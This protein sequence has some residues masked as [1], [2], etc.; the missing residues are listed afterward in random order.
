MIRNL[1][2][3]L[4]TAGVLVLLYIGYTRILSAPQPD[5]GARSDEVIDLGASAPRNPPPPLRI[6]APQ[7]DV[8][9]ASGQ[10]FA[11]SR[12]DPR[13]GREIGRIR[14][15]SWRPIDERS[16]QIEI[17][18]PELH[19]RL[20]GGVIVVV[21][22]QRAVLSVDTIDPARMTPRRGRFIGPARIVVDTC[23]DDERT[24]L[25]ERPDDR[26]TIRLPD[27]EFDL[28]RGTLQTEA[29]IEV[30]S[31]QATLAGRG[32]SLVWNQAENRIESLRIEAGEQLSFRLRSGL[33]E[34]GQEPA[35]ESQDAPRPV[36]SAD[37]ADAS[38]AAATAGSPRRIVTYQCVL[39]GGVDADQMRGPER[40]GGLV[41]DTLRLL[42]DTG[43]QPNPFAGAPRNQADGTSR[44]ASAPATQ[45]R[46]S[47]ADRNERLVVRWNGPLT[48]HPLPPPA[49]PSP[50]RRQFEA[51]GEKLR[52]ELGDRLITGG[53]LVYHDES[54]R[55]WL[56][57]DAGPIQLTVGQRLSVQA[58]S[59]YIDNA[60]ENI[61]L[62]GDVELA[63]REAGPTRGERM[64]IRCG[65]WAELHLDRRPESAAP[66][67]APSAA[68]SAPDGDASMLLG[69]SRLR[70]AV[71]VGSASIELDQQWL[72]AERIE[73]EFRPAE[74]ADEP[75]GQLLSRVVATG[76][77]RLA[78]VVGGRR[79]AGLVQRVWTRALIGP[80]SPLR[81]E[82][83]CDQLDLAFAPGET[84]RARPTH[85]EASG[86][87]RLLDP[88]NH[89][90]AKGRRLVA[91]LDPRGR[92]TRGTLLGTA[93]RAA[94]LYVRPFAVRGE[95]IEF[96]DDAETV[97]LPGPARLAFS[98]QRGLRG[99][100][101]SN[102][103]P[104]HVSCSERLQLDG[105]A[106]TVRF[107]GNVA[108]RSGEESLSADALTLFLSD[109]PPPVRR[110]TLTDSL[111]LAWRSFRARSAAAS[112]AGVGATT[113]VASSDDRLRRRWRKEPLRIV[114]NQAVAR[115]E[116]RLDAAGRPRQRE[117]ISAPE[118]TL[119][120][121]TRT[122]Q[123]AGL[124]TLL[125]ENYALPGVS[126]SRAADVLGLPSSLISDGPSQTAMSASQSMK[127]IVGDD[128][129][130]RRD[131][132]VMEGVVR[133]RHVAG[134]EIV[135]LEA[136]LPEAAG[137]PELLANLRDRNAW[138]ECDRLEGYFDVAPDEASKSGRSPIRLSW[139][140]ARGRV[141]LRDQERAVTRSV[142]AQELEFDRA[143]A[144]VKVRGG[145]NP[146][147]P[148]R[149]IEENAQSGHVSTPAL[150]RYI[151][152][153]L[154]NRTV[155]ADRTSGT[156]SG[157]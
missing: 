121:P 89:V 105:A 53:K 139:I 23:T 80:E 111:G 59:A 52:V 78:E 154:K 73:A 68:T 77:V 20:P 115:S 118:L 67:S 141:Y 47:P 149:V 61:K 131:W 90:G 8:S 128:G 18:Q 155:R 45:P 82:L 16:N 110:P 106:N 91:E 50:P 71:F 60:G 27:L 55:L 156:I 76:D 100:Q 127:Y 7:G 143:N 113:A 34:P 15:E 122:V 58:D 32:L 36:D 140:T 48:L 134:R 28:E 13:S 11:Y 109:V 135:D 62:V 25:D 65:L 75:L 157:R 148:A 14:G 70:S 97:T 69:S 94:L 126:D 86:L 138:L 33:L 6:Q 107:L 99:E 22:G 119:E 66:G 83:S 117:T 150:S 12:Y 43:R 51:T 116:T 95:R 98:S 29:R 40:I 146:P 4:S 145:D 44:P 129:P 26:I 1:V 133:C 56:Q 120:I 112:A 125:V 54:K 46:S 104:I 108:A 144:L 9:I 38:A 102:P 130:Q 101:R 37:G 74:R 63:L 147:L 19:Q 2:L 136:M 41:A 123:T 114:A 103:A 21:A 84:G 153:D 24:P 88:H 72:N 142:Y 31:T 3:M 92:P 49:K 42:V 35:A 5:E 17:V 132:V 64:M 124:T 151:E 57:N 137:R 152:I 87:V 81:R 93:Q 79:A 30:E 39:A 10:R 96:D 85:L